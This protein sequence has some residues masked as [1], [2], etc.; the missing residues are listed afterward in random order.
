MKIGELGMHCG[1]CILIEHCGEPWSD[2]AICCEERFKD[3]DKTKFLKLIET[4][5]R[6]SKK[7]RINDVHKRLLQG[8]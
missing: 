4:S 7:A 5:Q 3:V 2:I 6:K 1:E 8:E